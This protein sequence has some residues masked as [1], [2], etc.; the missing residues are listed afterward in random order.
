MKNPL[1][2]LPYL[3]Q[4]VWLDN[5]CRN[6]ITS[7][8][9]KRLIE[10]DGLRGLT[11]NP[12][13]FEKAIAGSS[14]YRDQLEA[15]ASQGLDAK[16]LYESI[17]VRDIQD[18][19]DIL[20][21]VYLES[22]G[23]DGFVSLEVSPLLAHEMQG[24][25]EE[26]R[27][28]WRTVARE[29]LMIKVPATPEGIP[30]FQQL[31]SEGINVNVTLLFARETYAQVAAAYLS[32]LESRLRQGGDLSKVASVASFFI[33][34]IDTAADNWITGRLKLSRDSGE[35]ARLRSV[36]GRV[37]NASA[38]NAYQK[39]I[40]IYHE[41]RWQALVRLGART[42][43]LL[44]ASTG[45]KNPNYSDVIYVEELIGPDT[46]NTMPPATLEAFRDH[47]RARLT[48]AR[49]VEEAISIMDLVEQIGIPFKELTDKL[50]DDGV[51]Q[52][53]DAFGKLLKAVGRNGKG[54]DH[55]QVEFLRLE[56]MKGLYQEQHHR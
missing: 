25:L 52:F 27:R 55:D 8:E 23:R 11:S 56:L 54:T 40:E 36:L 1:K 3:G 42:Q 46:V 20:R 2:S 4:S 41:D 43:R 51:K 48:L 45:T 38:K 44:W 6:L 31:I 33:S 22:K 28:L 10:E 14:D 32:G 17:A 53:T 30:A 15:P 35:Q 13:I 26:G 29:N 49:N 37:A 12:S 7:G 18:A 50:L 47:G 16:A 19:A 34:R 9:L 5:L 24:T 21:P 39:Y